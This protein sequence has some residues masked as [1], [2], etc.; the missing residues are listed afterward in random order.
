MQEKKLRSEKDYITSYQNK[1]YT[2]SYRSVNGTLVDLDLKIEYEA[3]TVFIVAEHRFEDMS[4][5][6]DMSILYVIETKDG[7]K[8]TALVNYSP[9]NVT[10]L[11]TFFSTIPKDNIS[12][13]A[14][15]LDYKS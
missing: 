5:P 6:G 2:Q 15:I 13:K 11:A 12:Q 8:G 1:G 14:N 4:N 7:N 9:S 10:E 3:E